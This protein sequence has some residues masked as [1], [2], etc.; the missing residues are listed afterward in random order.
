MNSLCD[1]E[2]DYTLF[3]T[4]DRELIFEHQIMP[5]HHDELFLKVATS[6]QKIDKNLLV[7]IF[8]IPIKLIFVPHE[9]LQFEWKH[10]KLKQKLFTL[11]KN[12][13]YEQTNQSE[14]SFI[15][16][17]LDE[18][19]Y[20]SIKN[21]A[22][23]IHIEVIDKSVVI[24]LRIDGVLQQYFRFSKELYFVISSLV[25]YLGNLDIAQKRLPMN[26]RFSRKIDEYT[27]D[28]RISTL[29]TIEGESIVLRI[30]DN[31][32]VQKDLVHI[33]FEGKVLDIVQ[34]SITLKQGL[35]LVTGPTGSGK[36]TSLYSMIQELNTKQKKIITVEDPVEYKI[37]GV[38][39]VNINEDI[40]LDYHRVLKNT[41]RQDP[42]ILMIGE[43]R[44]RDSLKIAIQAALTGHLVVATLHTNSA[45]ETIT[46]L[47]DL[48]AEPYLISATLKM[49]LSQRLLRTLCNHCKKKKDENFEKVGCKKCNFTG[50]MGREVV[51][52]ALS[53]D[54]EIK[55]AI[56]QQKSSNDMEKILLDLGFQTIQQSALDMVQRGKTSLQEYKSKI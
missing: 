56:F 13:L 34:K 6:N 19:L 49:V 55:E 9:Q 16:S 4:F 46:R 38:V 20:F 53:I 39:Q 1:Y 7:E 36:T 52:E 30:L 17:F 14:N 8:H 27:Y 15:Q 11:A 10:Y 40:E 41:L 23:D 48:G 24:R 28:I 45:V 35:L 47:L 21:N 22:S 5:L 12:S 33:G 50:Y 2:I 43:I 37:D 42:D 54:T 51:A 29:P 31:Q 18:V 25:K 44:D 26:S 32:N 3:K